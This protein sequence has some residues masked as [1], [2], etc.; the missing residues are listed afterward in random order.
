MGGSEWSS[1]G[2][3]QIQGIGESYSDAESN[4]IMQ[5]HEYS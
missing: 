3:E 2:E 4:P 5:S 1:N